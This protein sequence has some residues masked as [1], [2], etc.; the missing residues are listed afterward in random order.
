MTTARLP[1]DQ[2]ALDRLRRTVDAVSAAFSAKVVGQQNLRESLL[3]GLLA[4][5]HVLIESV[6]GLA[7]TTAARVIAESIDGGFA[8]IQCTPDLLPSDIIGTQVYE[9]ATNTFVTQLGPVHTNIVLL[10]EIN[11]SSA[12]TQSG[13]LEAM[14][15]RQ[16]TIA[17]TVHRIPDPFLVVATQNPVDQ[18]GT[19]P[20]L[21]TRSME[22][23]DLRP[24][25]PG[26]DVRDIDWKA[27]ARS[28]TVLIKRFVSERHHKILLVADAGRNMTAL[29]P[30]GEVKSDVALA[31]LGAFGLITASRADEIGMVYG[32]SSGCAT[33]RN[34]RGETHVEGMLDRFYLHVTDR[35][36]R[37]DVVSQLRYVAAHYRH[38]MLVVMVSDEP[39]VDDRLEEVVARV[40]ARHEVLWAMVSD[41]PAV[42]GDVDGYDVA[43]GRFVP[44]AA[45]LGPRL[46]ATYRP[47]VPLAVLLLIAAV[48]VA[49]RAIVLSAVLAR[50]GSPHRRSAL[51]G[52]SATTA[53]VLLLVLAAARPGLDS[54]G[55]RQHD[56]D[57]TATSQGANVN[58]FFVV[59]RSV[60]SRVTDYGEGTS[61][62]T[63]IRNDIAAVI[64]TYPK[65]RF[66]MIGFAARPSVDWPLSEDTWSLKAVVGDCRRT[67]VCP[68]TRHTGSMPPLPPMCFATNSSR[69]PSSIRARRTWCSTSA[70]VRAARRLHRAGSP[71]AAG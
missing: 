52:W 61:R 1:I 28:G 53:A 59:D 45:R 70:R 10:D 68:P 15:E 7:K 9:S 13:M 40:A 39:D 27:T 56:R 50:S 58:V 19:Y 36:D 67:S 63:G 6:P 24:Y 43:S 60:D 11:R 47:V 29:A 38:P 71:S 5:G 34:R 64:D 42:S 62:M 20:L 46:A 69:P 44:G 41:M 8:R 37:S 4:G 30:S 25:V 54:P 32:D 23:D 22:F 31:V 2:P 26:D 66:A 48:L 35:P 51:V 12:K 57:L 18:E 21:H 3:V 14:E 17:G 33:V 65:A 55:A 16:T 49:A